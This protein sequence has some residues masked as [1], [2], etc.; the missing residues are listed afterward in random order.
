M[1]FKEDDPPKISPPTSPIIKHN[2]DEDHE[3]DHAKRYMDRFKTDRS[4][5][6]LESTIKEKNFY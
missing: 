4:T 5:K 2:P 3:K 1:Q 6:F